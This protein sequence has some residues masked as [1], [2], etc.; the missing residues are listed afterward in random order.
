MDPPATMNPPATPRPHLDSARPMSTPRSQTVQSTVDSL[1]KT[2]FERKR[3]RPLL[4]K[5]V[6]TFQVGSTK[7]WLHYHLAALEAFYC[8]EKGK[9]ASM[10][11][12]E[13]DLEVCLE[14]VIKTMDEAKNLDTIKA[15]KVALGSYASTPRENARYPYFVKAANLALKLL[16]PV[17]IGDSKAAV[18]FDHPDSVLFM[19]HDPK[20]IRSYHKGHKT[21]RKPDMILTYRKHL[22]TCYNSPSDLLEQVLRAPPRALQWTEGLLFVEKKLDKK[23]LVG[24]GGAYNASTM[25]EEEGPEVIADVE[26]I[27]GELQAAFPDS[28]DVNLMTQGPPSPHRVASKAESE[29]SVGTKRGSEAAGIEEHAVS[30]KSQKVAEDQTANVME[31]NEADCP[32]VQ[33]AEY[34]AEA[35][36]NSFGRNHVLGIMLKGSLLNVWHYDHECPLQMI[37]FNFIKDLPHFFLLLFVLQ[38][39]SPKDWG[40]LPG[41]SDFNKGV[42]EGPEHGDAETQE[43]EGTMDLSNIWRY[44]GEFEGGKTASFKGRRADHLPDKFGINGRSTAVRIGSVAVTKEEGE[45][46]I[47][48]DSVLKLSWREK[49]RKREEEFIKKAHDEFGGKEFP[50]GDNPLDYLPKILASHEYSE[51]STDIIRTAVL[52]DL[53]DMRPLAA[54]VPDLT[55]MPK[56]DPI[57]SLTKKGDEALLDG[58][59]SLIYCHAMLWSIGIEHGDISSGNLMVYPKDGNPKLCDFDLA[60][61]ADL[62]RPAGYSNTGTWAFMAIELLSKMAM[63]GRVPRLYRHE[64]ESFVAVL[65]WVAFRYRDGVLISN[66]PLGDWINTS[67]G[68]CKLAREDTYMIIR[69]N[70]E[71][72]PK[73]DRISPESKLWR[74]LRDALNQMSKVDGLKNADRVDLYSADPGS[75]EALKLQAKI[76]KIDGLG[77]IDTLFVWQLFKSPRGREVASLLQTYIRAPKAAVA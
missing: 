13:K 39:F 55:G 14:K 20:Y 41:F 36:F 53:N 37:G 8:E 45:E 27:E 60:H 12:V 16:Q 71:L 59:L 24:P 10:Q 6:K 72:E 43:Q 18:N 57:Q 68:E 49:N 25:L 5:D 23:T 9:R 26:E 7:R 44:E 73:Q 2:Q 11:Q 61:F 46:T 19:T 52:R 17:Q 76:E 66:P 48:L 51:F 74:I 22:Q 75:E 69:D 56:Y 28:N 4:A 64:I 33:L 15:I 77:Y 1:Q 62:I 35:M 38:R 32:I 50:P 54:R 42:P 58:F 34:A 67:Y 30:T 40:H 63:G 70:Q 29:A 3:V 31:N 65:I 47:D 21:F